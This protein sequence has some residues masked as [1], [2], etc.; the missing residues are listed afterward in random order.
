MCDKIYKNVQIIDSQKNNNLII[1]KKS[2][3][4]INSFN[5]NIKLTL[6]NNNFIII[7]NSKNIKINGNKIVGGCEVHKSNN[8]IFNFNEIPYNFESSFSSNIRINSSLINNQL[9][10]NII[11]SLDIKINDYKIVCNPFIKLKSVFPNM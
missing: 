7:H 8:I 9:L 10:Y 3:I 6:D 5:F 11:N 2:I 1:N 4:I